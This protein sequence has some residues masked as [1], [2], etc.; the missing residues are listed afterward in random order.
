ML[1]VE[2]ER[3]LLLH[4]PTHSLALLNENIRARAALLR[5]AVRLDLEIRIEHQNQA[6]QA[7]Q[8]CALNGIGRHVGLDRPLECRT[9]TSFRRTP[10]SS[11]VHILGGR[12]R[13]IQ[14]R[15]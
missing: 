11:G 12:D 2:S 15:R 13:H 1:Y 9:Q 8:D 4:L 7:I 14:L 6:R 3:C 10:H 5:S